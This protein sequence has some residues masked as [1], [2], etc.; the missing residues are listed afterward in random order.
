MDQNYLDI[1]EESLLKKN[2][3]LDEL[4]TL[5]EGQY[6]CI[7]DE[8]KLLESLDPFIERKGELI[9]ELEVLDDGFE[10]LYEKVA[11]ELKTDREKYSDQIKRMQELITKITEKSTAS[12]AQEERNKNLIDTYFGKR[13]TEVREGRINSKAAMNYY[14]VQS[15]SAYTD[16]QFLDSKK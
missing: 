3:V 14:R 12:Q 7:T 6:E 15:N 5:S 8:S 1:L 4:K 10:T 16:S 11:D 2:R 9:E 13:R